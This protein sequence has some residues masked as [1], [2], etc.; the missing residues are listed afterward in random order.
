MCFFSRNLGFEDIKL[1]C[2]YCI[3]HGIRE[4]GFCLCLQVDPNQV[5]PIDEDRRQTSSIH[6]NQLSEF[7]RLSETE[8]S[9]W[10]VLFQLKHRTMNSVE[11]VGNYSVTCFEGTRHKPSPRLRISICTL[12]GDDR[13]FLCGPRE[14]TL[15]QSPESTSAKEQLQ[16][17]WG[18]VRAQLALGA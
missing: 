8:F 9:L 6:W 3:E 12:F 17:S 11:N 10:I 4:P 1:I 5:G 7:H 14:D 15:S 16:G 2:V 18:A 13:W